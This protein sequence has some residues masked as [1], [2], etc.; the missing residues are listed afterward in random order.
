M[1]NFENPWVVEHH[2]HHVEVKFSKTSLNYLGTL[3]FL[4]LPNVGAQLKTGMPSIGIEAENWVG[5]SK[6]PVSGTV[7]AVNEKVT[8]FNSKNLTSDDW[9]LQLTV[10]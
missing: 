6:V 7:T 9:V 4:D 2:H 8:D 3:V 10:K 1:V 5:T